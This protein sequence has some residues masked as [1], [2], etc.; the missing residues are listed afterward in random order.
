MQGMEGEESWWEGRREGRVRAHIA[1][2][3]KRRKGGGKDRERTRSTE[4]RGKEVKQLCS[5]NPEGQKE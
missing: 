3:K 2:R 5:H 1:R 4:D